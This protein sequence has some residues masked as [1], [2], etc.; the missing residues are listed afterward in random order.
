L[1]KT[2]K[3]YLDAGKSVM[4]LA[5]CSYMLDPLKAVLRK[6]AIPFANRFRLRR[7]DWNPLRHGNERNPAAADRVLAFLTAMTYQAEG[8][9]CPQWSARGFAT[10]AECLRTEGLFRDG[11]KDWLKSLH[12]DSGL[13]DPNGLLQHA[14]SAFSRDFDQLRF[15]TRENA[16]QALRWWLARCVD[17][18]G[19][20]LRF[21]VDVEIA[22]IEAGRTS[23]AADPLMTG[24]TALLNEPLVT[25]GTV[26]SVK[27]GE[28]A[29][30]VLCPD[31][32]AAAY[33][34][35]TTNVGGRDEIRRTIYVGMTRASETLILASPSDGR[36]VSWNF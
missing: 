34:C 21:P 18:H 24:R 10:W 2:V 26:T 12:G 25:V 15:G 13:L 23:L 11:A 20:S 14:E 31:L 19:K 22:A 33:R 17:R 5:S 4:F 30:V 3:P 7:S 1:L 32:S 8:E 35:W 29:V 28:A 36:A 9:A 6:Q 27:G 16:A